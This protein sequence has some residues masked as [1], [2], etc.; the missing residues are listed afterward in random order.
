MMKAKGLFPAILLLIGLGAGTVLAQPTIQGAQSGTL[1]PGTFIVV[2]NLTVNRNTSLTIA[3]GTTLLFS[4]HFNFKIYGT[5]NAV[6]TASDSILFVRQRLNSNCEWGGLRFVPGASAISIVSYALFEGGRYQVWP[7][8][9]GG[10]I[11]AEGVGVTISHC[12]FTNNYSASGGALYFN[13][14]PV[15]FTNNVVFNNSAGNGGGLYVYNCTGVNVSNNFFAKN[16]S[17]ST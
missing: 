5:L 3:P 13:N 10:A 8:A 15:T 7:D 14:A 12:W 17:T 6:G 11:Y 16:S 4:G 1:G 9:N 2:G